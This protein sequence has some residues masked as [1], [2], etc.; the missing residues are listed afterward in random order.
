MEHHLLSCQTVAGLA[1]TAPDR[2]DMKQEHARRFGA[3]LRSQAGFSLLEVLMV[4][5]ILGTMAAMAMMVSP[6][7]SQ[8]ARAEAG[9][10]Q[11]LDVMR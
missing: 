11:V 8:H 6:T 9:I 3:G 10:S 2:T 5:G 4:V 7:Y 1:R